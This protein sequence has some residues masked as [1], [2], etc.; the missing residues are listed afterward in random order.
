MREMEQAQKQV[1]PLRGLAVVMAVPLLATVPEFVSGNVLIG[2]GGGHP[3]NVI[4]SSWFEGIRFKNSSTLGLVSGN[5]IGV[6]SD[7]I[8]PLGNG[9]EGI[10]IT[11][12]SSRHLIGNVSPGIG[13]PNVIAHNKA[14]IAI[15]GGEDHTIGNN[16]IR[17]NDDLGIDL[18]D[19]SSH[20]NDV[21]PNDSGDGDSG[22]N[23]MQNRPILTAATTN[24]VDATGIEG[25][26]DSE[27]FA[28]YEIRFY[29]SPVA[30]PSGYGEGATYLGS[31]GVATDGSGHADIVYL[32]GGVV[33]PGEVVT[34]TATRSSGSTRRN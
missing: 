23:H 30:D 21:D 34:A 18:D 24:Q 12:S 8:T 10:S 5:F 4:G 31:I 17:D 15:G 2:A 9:R 20:P 32:Y 7:G 16:S 3:G 26:L 28:S 27:P 33:A 22:P 14:G 11:D 1:C 6:G 13:Q 25:D 19:G 29:G